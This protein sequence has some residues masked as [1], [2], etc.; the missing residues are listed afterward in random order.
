MMTL[1]FMTGVIQLVLGAMRAG[2]VTTFLGDTVVAGFTTGSAIL[3]MS[4]QVKHLLGISLSREEPLQVLLAL[5]KGAWQHINPYSLAVSAVCIYSMMWIK[6][7]NKKYLPK[8]I[9]PEQ[10][11]ASST[12]SKASMDRC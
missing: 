1:S 2:A 12:A 4:S 11:R 5:A 9:I 6:D 7:M 3:I 10:V 8:V